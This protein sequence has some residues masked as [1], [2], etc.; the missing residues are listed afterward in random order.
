[1]GVDLAKLR[2]LALRARDFDEEPARRHVA[3]TP[4][5]WELALALDPRTVLEMVE[6]LEEYRSLREDGT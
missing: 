6:Q 5:E 3:L 4:A 2:Q 1:M